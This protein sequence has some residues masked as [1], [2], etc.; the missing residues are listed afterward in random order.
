LCPDAPVD[1]L[2]V[3]V[4][5]VGTLIS[6]CVLIDRRRF[7][8]RPWFDESLFFY[9]E[10]HELGFRA[11]LQGFDCLIVPSARCL[12]GKGTIGVS[13]RD[14]GRYT[15]IR[16]RHTIRNRW[17]AV[18]M[19]Y[20]K[21][22]VLRFAPALAAFEVSQL[23]GSTRKGWLSHW[24]WAVGSVG[25]AF[26]RVARARRAMRRGRR[27]P[28]LDVLVDGPFPYNR[29]VRP[30]TAERTARRV[31]DAIAAVNWRLVGRPRRQ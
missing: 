5:P 1:Q 24:L 28:D 14:T 30:T 27:R 20:Q 4:R 23:L 21:R 31:V 26:P 17:L 10:D 15:E 12:H 2:D 6:C 22:T 8:D 11:T 3:A 25:R 9:L 16:I 18:L 7:G 29:T 19:S 13:I